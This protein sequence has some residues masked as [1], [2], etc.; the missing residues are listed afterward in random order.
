MA[1]CRPLPMGG[2]SSRSPARGPGHVVRSSR[3][4]PRCLVAEAHQAAGSEA[5]QPAA[6][7]Q[8]VGPGGLTIPARARPPGNR[9]RA[10]PGRP[11]WS[12]R[13]PRPRERRCYPSC[14]RIQQINVRQVVRDECHV[15]IGQL[16]DIL[17]G[18]RRVILADR[19]PTSIQQKYSARRENAIQESRVWE[20][21]TLGQC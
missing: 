1:W 16:I 12:T 8:A 10:G 21:D 7:D 6:S 2:G 13:R 17:F 18:Q 4:E 20:L 9:Y 3:H 11:T 5:V 19:V 14:D 15:P